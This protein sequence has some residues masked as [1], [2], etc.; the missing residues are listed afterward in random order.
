MM[1]DRGHGAGDR[2][3]APQG[4]RAVSVREYRAERAVA[5]ASDTS[6]PPSPQSPVPGS[7]RIL[8]IDPGS[9]RTGVGVIEVGGNG[10]LRCLHHCMLSVG[11]E[12]EF[13]QRLARIYD[14]LLAIIDQYHPAE[15]AIERVFMARNADSA[16]KL[17]QARGAATSRKYSTWCPCCW[18][19]TNGCRPM[20]PMR[21]P[22]R[23]HTRTRAK[24]RSASAF[25]LLHGDAGGDW[26]FARNAGSQT[27][28]VDR[29]GR[30]RCRLRTGS[31]DV[32][33]V[34]LAGNRPRSDIVDALRDQGRHRGTLWFPA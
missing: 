9:V 24:A 33:A 14:G 15:A 18:V 19:C 20:R 17:G 22:W 5:R 4:F 3:P 12:D 25:R 10:T 23:S 28:A 21:W 6:M 16:L 27:A 1:R 13:P 31:A 26:P 7:I 30:R 8:G 29:A 11:G 2:S 32:H 34:R